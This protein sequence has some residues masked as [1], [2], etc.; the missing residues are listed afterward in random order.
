M[1]CKCFPPFCRLFFH[2]LDRVLRNTKVFNFDEVQFIKLYFIAWAFGIISKKP[3]LK[4]RSRI[5]TLMFSSK[6]FIVLAL[7]FRSLIYFD[8]VL[9]MVWGT[10]LLCSFLCG[11]PFVTAQFVERGI[12]CH[13]IILAPLLKINWP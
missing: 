3:L 5:F 6:S 13:W 12:F 1:V 9:H 8:L 10:D 4:P 7:I 11:Y 2:F